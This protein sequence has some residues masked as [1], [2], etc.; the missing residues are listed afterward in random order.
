MASPEKC[1]P[2]VVVT[3]RVAGS[4]AST[5]ASLTATFGRSAKSLRSE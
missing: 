1:S 2:S 3:V 5:S 4:I